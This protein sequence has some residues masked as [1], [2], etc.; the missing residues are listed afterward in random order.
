[1]EINKKKC[2]NFREKSV[3][4]SCDGVHENKSTN[5]SIDV[6]ST[7]FKNCKAIYPHKLVRPLGKYKLDSQ[8][9]LG[10][11]LNDINQNRIRITQFIADNQKRAIAKCSMNHAGWYACEYCYAKGVKIDIISNI[12]TRNKL[13]AQINLIEEKITECQNLQQTEENVNKTEH[14]LSLKKDLQKSINNMKKK[15]NILWPFST[16]NSSNRSRSSILN[17]VS[18]TEADDNDLSVDDRKG[19]KGRSLLFEVPDFN[20]VYDVPVEYMHCGCLGVIKKLVEL[21]FSVGENCTRKTKRKLSSPIAFDRLMA[22]IKVPREF[23]RRIRNLD[24]A[25]LKAIEFRNIYIF[26][27]PLILECI[28]SNAKERH[29]WLYLAYMTRSSVIPSEEFRN[30]DI[31]D[32]EKSCKSFF[33]LYE[34]LFGEKNCT[35]NTHVYCS[36]LTEIRTHGP[37]TET[38]AFKFESFYG[39]LRRSF[40]PGTISPMKQALQKIILRRALSYHCCRNT[41]TVSNYDTALECNSLIYQFVNKSYE[42]YSVKEINGEM[43]TCQ[44]I[45]KYPAVF[46]ETPNLVWSKVGVFKKGPLSSETYQLKMSDTCGKVINVGEYMI[47]CPENVLQ[48]K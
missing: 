5:V 45:G 21:T 44:K 33:N 39:E 7:C 36:H 8:K 40:V 31:N 30:I 35:Y 48:E 2:P 12:A 28:E 1:M 20:F 25:V 6:Y 37:L 10:D 42:L 15:S 19:V 32:I 27:F 23:P 41:I 38:S 34:R 26:F 47:T 29:L 24:F 14:L 46:K 11:V 18:K 4:L 9:Q 13:I 43:L 3:Q 16:Y 22:L 17:I